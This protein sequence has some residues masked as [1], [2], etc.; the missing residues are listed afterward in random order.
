[1]KK[2]YIHCQFCGTKI[3][4]YKERCRFC[5]LEF[6]GPPKDEEAEINIPN[7]ERLGVVVAEN[8]SVTDGVFDYKRFDDELKL[9]KF[10]IEKWN[11]KSYF[12]T[13]VRYNLLFQIGTYIA[14][15]IFILLLYSV[16]ILGDAGIVI[17][18][19]AVLGSIIMV[20]INKVIFKKS[21]SFN[22]TY[23]FY[24]IPSR[25]SSERYRIEYKDLD[26]LEIILMKIFR[27]QILYL[28]QKKIQISWQEF[29]ICQ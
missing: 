4:R 17:L 24:E 9:N 7:P 28:R 23:I 8:I 22:G 1:M 25:Y 10:D 21:L 19:L 13:G 3:S 27:Q 14:F 26:K 29:L 2:H 11:P 15:L 18:I 16:D 5:S 20:P 6:I 12:K